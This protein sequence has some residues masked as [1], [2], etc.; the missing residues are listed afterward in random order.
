[1]EHISDHIKLHSQ[2]RYSD[3]TC[4]NCFFFQRYPLLLD[5][6]HLDLRQELLPFVGSD[7]SQEM[8]KPL[9]QSTTRQQDHTTLLT[10]NGG[11]GHFSDNNKC[12]KLSRVFHCSVFMAHT[13][14]SARNSFFNTYRRYGIATFC[15]HGIFYVFFFLLFYCYFSTDSS[16][17][18]FF[19]YLTTEKL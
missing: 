15:P 6:R 9:F 16:D 13:N 7:D 12:S 17:N 18:K 8:G 1:M 19:F 14:S 5:V 10:Q 3:R 2:N 11:L 4:F